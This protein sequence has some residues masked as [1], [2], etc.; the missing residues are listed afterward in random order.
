MLMNATSKTQSKFEPVAVGFLTVVF[1]M[2][3]RV[4]AEVKETWGPLKTILKRGI[5]TFLIFQPVLF[6]VL[7]VVWLTR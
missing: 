6:L 1:F 4:V 7:F 5:L 3:K 2:W